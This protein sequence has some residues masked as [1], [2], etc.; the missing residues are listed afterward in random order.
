MGEDLVKC[1]APDNG[2]VWIHGSKRVTLD[3]LRSE[4][5]A[6]DVGSHN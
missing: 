5:D 3:N 6:K 2:L 4:V 1:V